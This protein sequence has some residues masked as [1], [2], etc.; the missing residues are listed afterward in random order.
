MTIFL[1]IGVGSQALYVLGNILKV[2]GASC[3]PFFVHPINEGDANDT[4]AVLQIGLSYACG[5]LLAITVCSATS[6]GEPYTA[7]VTGA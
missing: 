7:V 4:A 5:I 6:G 2:E 1:S 3:A